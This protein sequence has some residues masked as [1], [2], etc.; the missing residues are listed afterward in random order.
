MSS[1]PLCD[2]LKSIAT[3][4]LVRRSV[5][6]GADGS[7]GTG[8]R[9]V[10]ALPIIGA[11]YEGTLGSEPD[12]RREHLELS[13]TKIIETVDGSAIGIP[14]APTEKYKYIHII[15]FTHNT[16]VTRI[17]IYIYNSNL[18]SIVPHRF[19]SITIQLITF[20]S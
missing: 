14:M 15:M 18:H 3:P 10:A 11:I 8:R 20:D 2:A 5:Q 19:T 7:R 6:G 12:Q 9:R 16:Y 4:F 17:H 13:R 1:A